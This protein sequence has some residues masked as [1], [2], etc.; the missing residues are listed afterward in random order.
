A[1]DVRIGQLNGRES[2]QKQGVASNFTNDVGGDSEKQARAQRHSATQIPWIDIQCP[3]NPAVHLNNPCSRA[4][5]RVTSIFRFPADGGGL[6]SNSTSS[7][8]KYSAVNLPSARISS[9]EA[10]PPRQYG[11]SMPVSIRKTF[12]RKRLRMVA[13]FCTGCPT[14]MCAAS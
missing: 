4:L 9:A 10:R 3:L 12:P 14:T 2:R 11:E 1:G 5:S 6:S 8:S 7:P 13:V